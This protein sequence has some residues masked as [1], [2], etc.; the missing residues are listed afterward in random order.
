MLIALVACGDDGTSPNDY[1]KYK[2]KAPSTDL[3][4]GNHNPGMDCQGSCHDHGF[5]IAG[6]VFTDG[7]GTTPAVGATVNVYDG[8]QTLSMITATNGN[9]YTKSAVKLP[10]QVWVSSCPSVEIMPDSVDTNTGLGASCN[11]G[12]CHNNGAGTGVITL[13][14]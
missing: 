3:P 14:Q 10:F 4:N 8:A 6:T 9:F 13:N 2:C 5:T 11:Q 1:S 12:I 7:T